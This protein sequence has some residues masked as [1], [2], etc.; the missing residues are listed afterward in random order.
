[1][2]TTSGTAAPTL[3]SDCPPAGYPNEKTRCLPCPRRPVAAS[4]SELLADALFVLG[5]V[6][7]NN[8]IDAGEPGKAWSG[9]FVV[10]E[11]RRVLAAAALAGMSAHTPAHTGQSI[12]A[13]PKAPHQELT[14]AQRAILE[15]V[16]VLNADSVRAYAARK[17][18]Q[19]MHSPLAQAMHGASA[20]TML[21]ASDAD[22]V[23]LRGEAMAH[24][25]ACLAACDGWTV[26]TLGHN[27]E[28][29]FGMDLGADE[30]DEIARAAIANATGG[31]P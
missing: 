2:T 26:E 12:Y 30:C 21:E 25:Q 18:P 9:R 8:R 16:P 17:W 29:A 15:A 27:I 24:A 22:A 14:A 19:A 10:E 7:K 3:C 6:D 13:D 23:A 28:S 4:P 11:V 20:M 5:M 1:M 31:A